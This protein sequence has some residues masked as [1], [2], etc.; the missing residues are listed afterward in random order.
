[1]GRYNDINIV[2]IAR[3]KKASLWIDGNKPLV[4]SIKITR[5]NK[6]LLSNHHKGQPKKYAIPNKIAAR[7]KK[8]SFVSK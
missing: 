2:T 5:V 4:K 7:I 6:T 1:M 3:I 8:I